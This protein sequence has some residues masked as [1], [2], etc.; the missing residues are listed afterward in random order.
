MGTSFRPVATGLAVTAL[1]LCAS[2]ALAQRAQ[3]AR[4]SAQFA[5]MTGSG[6][7]G[8]D[9]AWSARLPDG[10]DVWLFGDTFLGGVD[11]AG[12]RNAQT[13][14]VRNSMVVENRYGSMRTLAGG[15]GSGA[16][17]AGGSSDDWYWPGP[18][19]V[20]RSEL[21]VPMAHIVRTGPGGWDFAA[22]GTSIASFSLPGLELRS[23]TP[24]ATPPGVNMASASLAT[25]R[26][27]YVYGTR[28]DG[29]TSKAAF[30]ARVR[31]H[32]LRRRW[33]YWTGA[34]WSSD[35]AAA[36]PIANGVSDQFSVVRRGHRWLLITQVPCSRDI[37]AFSARKPQGVWTA[38][39]RVAEIPQIPH[40]ITYN[41]VVHGEY[42]RGRALTL[43]YSVNGQT[44]DW[45]YAD[46]A[47]YR[48]RFMTI[49]I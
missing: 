12:R 28:S 24:I 10:R 3:A 14:I 45:V 11:A 36:A 13:P 31:G 35:A 6:W 48:P 43:G 30:V 42:S 17:V 19:V 39:G 23:V 25:R 32:D 29:G 34:A 15:N 20:G 46:A 9:A 33:S 37:V 5:S 22:E 4:L 2:P 44:E 16:L 26:F 21:Q 40:A 47:L 7:T 27:T 38:I 1:L 41:A 8:G 49:R 18:P